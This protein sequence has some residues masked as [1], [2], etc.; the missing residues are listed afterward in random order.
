M[1]YQRPPAYLD[2]RAR[3]A[4]LH[5]FVAEARAERALSDDTCLALSHRLEALTDE[6][7]AAL[8]QA[9]R[10]WLA[11]TPVGTLRQAA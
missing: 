3:E 4:F 10:G 9:M 2:A 1:S 11:T 8:L 5:S 7:V 6:Q